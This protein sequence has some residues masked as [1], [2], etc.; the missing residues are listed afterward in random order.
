MFRNNR[1]RYWVAWY[2]RWHLWLILV[3]LLLLCWL[4]YLSTLPAPQVSLALADPSAILQ[5]DKPLELIGKAP[6]NGVVRVY[7]GDKA[8]GETRADADGN[9]KI[10]LTNIPTGAHAL[11][12]SVE[13]NGARIESPALN[14]NVSVPV[15]AIAPTIAPTTTPP[16]TATSAPP[17]ATRVPPT[18]TPVL[19]TATPTLAAGAVQR[20]GKDNAEMV[21]VPAGDFTFGDEKSARTLYLDAFWID[22]F[23]VTNAQFQQFVDATGYKTDAEKQGWGFEYIS[24]WEPV[25]GIFWRAP[26]GAGSSIADRQ[27]QPVVLVSWNDANAYCAWAGKRL[28]TEAHWEKSARGTDARVYPWGNNWDG[29]RLNFCDANC[30]F[31]WKDAGANDG[32]AESAPVG[33]YA[34]GASPYGVLDLAGNVWEWLADWFDPDYPQTMPARNPP[35]P[36]SGQFKVLR[37]GAWSIEQFYARTTSRFSEPVDYRER[38]VGVRCVQ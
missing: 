21:Y 14:L 35:G 20:R 38:S 11:Q 5:S 2:D 13:V 37:G 33:S 6:A 8:L 19:P 10:A 17:T 22:K 7:D 4:G 16:P 18:A 29:A 25:N 1:P 23:E 12:A 27:K 15:A 30:A 36:A 34:S 3:L 32:N 28:P 26:R 9:F 24:M 31:S